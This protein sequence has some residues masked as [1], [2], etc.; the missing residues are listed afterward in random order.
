[1]YLAAQKLAG[2]VV[3]DTRRKLYGRN[4]ASSRKRKSKEDED[5]RKILQ[6][7]DLAP[8]YVRKCVRVCSCMYEYLY[9]Q[10]EP[11]KRVSPYSLVDQGVAI[12]KPDFYLH[13]ERSEM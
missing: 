11:I 8:R 5:T 12:Q 6:T 2:D 3:S 1:M 13:V 4:M 7:V 10:L 9:I